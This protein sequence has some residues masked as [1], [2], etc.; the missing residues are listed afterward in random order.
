MHTDTTIN[1]SSFSLLLVINI[2][3]SI[4][5][6]IIFVEYAPTNTFIE[7]YSTAIIRF[8]IFFKIPALFRYIFLK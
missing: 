6:G 1:N 7:S 2:E 4:V 8:S 3:I 5:K